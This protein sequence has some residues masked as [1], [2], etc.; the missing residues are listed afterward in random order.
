MKAKLFLVLIVVVLVGAAGCSQQNPMMPLNVLSTVYVGS[1]NNEPGYCTTLFA[2]QDIDVGTVCVEVIDNGDT[3]D[4]CITYTTVNGWELIESHLWVGDTFGGYPQNRK[5]NPQVGLFPYHSGD[6]SGATSYTFCLDL[7]EFGTEGGALDLCDLILY[8][9]AHAVVGIDT[10]GDGE[11]DQTETGWGDGQRMVTKGNWATFFS[12]ELSCEFGGGGNE[13]MGE[14]AFAYD[15]SVATCFIGADFDD[16]GF[17]DGY[18]RWGWSNGPYTPGTYY[19]DIYAGAGQ[20]ILENGVLV[21][22][23]TLDYDG[24]TATVTYNTCGTY[25]IDEIHLYVGN[26]P[27][28][29]DGGGYTISPG[30]QP[31]VVEGIGSNEWTEVI[32]GLS[33]EIYVFAHA[34]VF[35]DYSQGDCGERG[36]VPPEPPCTQYGATFTDFSSLPLYPSLT[37]GATETF[38]FDLCDGKTVDVDVTG[39]PSPDFKMGDGVLGGGFWLD[40]HSVYGDLNLYGVGRMNTRCLA[41][42]STSDPYVGAN[43]YTLTWDFGDTPLDHTNCFFI[44][45]FYRTTNVATMTAYGPDGASVVDNSVF[46]FEWLKGLTTDGRYS[47]YEPVAW[48]SAAGTLTKG[49]STGANSGYGF[50]SIPEGTEIGK[51]V[52]DVYDSA[53]LQCDELNWGIGCVVCVQ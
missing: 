25:W 14:T 24:A 1:V 47:F 10:D 23:L 44:G 11:Y 53:A 26:D 50:F 16:D 41:S 30:Q 15:C 32:G 12:I 18:N 5:G 33:G 49:S 45:Q 9:A 29:D 20:C 51:L 40:E 19:L 13:E 7:N 28:Y 21:G 43:G 38:V 22:L 35:G 4:L 6:I 39:I 52:F 36:C 48:N 3:E 46:A 34:V 42:P 17:E 37:S 2:G 8:A 31:I 27:L